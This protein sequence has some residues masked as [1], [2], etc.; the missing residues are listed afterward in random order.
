VTRSLLKL[1]LCLLLIT[2]LQSQAGEKLSLEAMQAQGHLTIGSSLHPESGLVPGQRAE[3]ILE[4]ATDRWF[5]GGTRIGVPEVPGLVILQTEQFA[6]NASEQRN[7]QSWVIQR[8]TLDI[9]GQRP[10]SFTVPPLSLKI[11]VNSASSDSLQGQM[12]SPPLSF[13]VGLPA[14]LQDLEHWVASPDFKVEQHFDKPLDDLQAGDAFERKV[15][16]SAS[17]VMA[18][19]LPT[20]TAQRQPGLSAYPAPPELIDSNN[21]GVKLARRTQTIS[22]MIETPGEYLLPAQDYFWWDTGLQ[23]L[24]VLS[25]PATAI[26]VGG[27]ATSETSVTETVVGNPRRAVILAGVAVVLGLLC[28]LGA[29]YRPWQV[30]PGLL[31]PLKS[32]WQRLLELRKPALAKQLNPRSGNPG[33]RG[34]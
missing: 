15:I 5:S 19:M 9:F 23:E 32:L 14:P 34:P 8:W 1:T 26:R 33:S 18:M 25:L 4:I 10:G 13:T 27:T 7:G 2:P 20:F 17:D 21:R 28:W 12:Y 31:N 11:S 29:R 22:Y 30:L 3:L 16:F 24:S 6:S